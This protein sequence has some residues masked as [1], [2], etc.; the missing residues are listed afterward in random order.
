MKEGEISPVIETEV[1]LHILLCEKIK[2]GKRTSFSKAAPQMKLTRAQLFLAL[3][4]Q[5]PMNGK[6]V[7]NPYKTWK[8]VDASLPATKIEVLGPPPTSGTRDAF[9]ELAMEKG[10]GKVAGAKDLGLA[11]KACHAIRED[12]GYVEAGE[13]DVL[14]V[15][16]LEA[17]PDAFGIFGFSFLDQNADKIKG[18]MIDGVPAEFEKI[19]GG[20]YPVSRSLY[21][22]V[23]QQHVGVIPG[24]KEFVGEFTNEN[25]WGPDGYLI[26][27]GLI[28]LPDTDRKAVMESATSLQMLS[29]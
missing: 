5:V 2:P 23:K 7:D 17:N 27:K 1:G 8:D 14:I 12:G 24:I 19:A 4:K 29:M 11:K 10:C 20:D 28:P 9:A 18:A 6:L 26:D 21:F 15:R 25:A 3:A 22:Y 16:K 13:N